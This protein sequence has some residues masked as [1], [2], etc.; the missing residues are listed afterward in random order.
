MGRG[1]REFPSG[2]RVL[3]PFSIRPFERQARTGAGGRSGLGSNGFRPAAVLQFEIEVT[4][5]GAE[6]GFNEVFPWA[7]LLDLKLGKQ[8]GPICA[9]KRFRIG[10][11]VLKQSERAGACWPIVVDNLGCVP[12]RG[13]A[14]YAQFAVNIGKPIGG[15]CHGP[16]FLGIGGGV[17]NKRG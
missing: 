12:C 1:L 6:G 14:H 13:G 10:E 3:E 15:G 17:E 8:P 2:R 7:R 9:V 16:I 5:I 11:A 4:A